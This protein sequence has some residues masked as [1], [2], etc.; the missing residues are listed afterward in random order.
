MVRYEGPRGG[1]GLTE[2]LVIL[3]AMGASGLTNSCALVTDG[4]MSGFAKGCYVCQVSPEAAVGGP[5]AVVRDGDILTID[6]DEGTLN[7][8]LTA[9]E[10]DRR[11][12]QWKPPRPRINHGFLA[13]YA[14]CANPPERGA[15]LPLRI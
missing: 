13:L 7:I 10:L 15:G 3:E 8:Q 14:K 4:K 5:L 11:L 2:T 1:P 9:R 12:E 6:V